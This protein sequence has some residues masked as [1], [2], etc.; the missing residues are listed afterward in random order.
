M[1]KILIVDDEVSF[2]LSLK[3]GLDK[4]RNK[5]EVR[6]AENGLEAVD[7]LKQEHID[8]LVTDLKLPEMNGFEI[9]AWVSRHQPQLPV[10]VMSAFGTPEIEARLAKLDTLQF[11]EKPLDL[12]MLEEAIFNGLKAGGKSYIRGITPATFLQL[13]K[14]EQKNCTLKITAAG[15]PAY[16]Y[17]RRG[18][19][20]DA[21]CDDLRGMP[22]ALEIVS[23]DEA[24]IEM[25]GVC[26]R[27]EDVIRMPMEH[28]LIE[29]FRR[30]DEAAEQ[31]KNRGVLDQPE[32]SGSS[33]QAAQSRRKRLAEI[34]HQLT[35]VQEFAV[36]DQNSVLRIKNSGNCSLEGIDP[37]A[38]EELIAPLGEEL[39]SGHY[40]SVILNATGRKRYL[41]LHDQGQR[42]F[43]KIQPGTQI[44]KL[45]KEVKR[46]VDH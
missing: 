35:A 28:L 13:M 45:I 12:E 14:A 33:K 34:M 16:L 10:I 44:Q 29:A 19:L 41:L 21:E 30:K 31:E 26:R 38:V 17:I 40:V 24:E 9:L 2:L 36:F 18:E 27:Q 1:K 15:R 43:A 4:H 32:E 6:T 46:Q 5:F 37:S 22:A 23:W 7:V 8:L 39:H 25:D 11:L 20:I 42:V 3:D